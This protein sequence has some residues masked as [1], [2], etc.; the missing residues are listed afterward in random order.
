M[1]SRSS[2]AVVEDHR[3][4]WLRYYRHL[5]PKGKSYTGPLAL[6]SRVHDALDK[7]YKGEGPLVE[8]YNALVEGDKL[9]AMSAGANIETYENE[10]ELGRIMLEG[11][12][13]WREETGL[14]SDLEVVSTEEM[15]SAPMV[16]GRV[17]LIAKIDMRVRRKSDGVR[18]FRD[19]KTSANFADFTKTAH[20]NEQLL[21][22]MLIEQLQ[23]EEK[24]RC[25]GGMFTLLKKVKRTGSARPP[26]FDQIEVRHNVFALRSFWAR[27]HGTLT[28]MLSVRDQLDQ[29]ADHH[30][31]AYPR[32]SRDCSWSCDFY[33]ICPLFDDGSAVEA[34]IHELYES[35]SP[36]EYYGDD[37]PLKVSA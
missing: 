4:W 16:D 24:N 17:S 21:T 27:L 14:D 26:F 1:R 30:A 36:Y 23:V 5:L 7:H 2:R 11:F 20:M 31:V 34:A 12:D 8:V 28:D 35:R 29:G 6:G 25:A 37:D 33:A 18:L 10:A 9:A 19:W 3:K 15:L 32:P 13:Q 22:Y